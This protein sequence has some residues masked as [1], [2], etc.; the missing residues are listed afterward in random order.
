MRL[1]LAI[2]N[3][4]GIGDFAIGCRGSETAGGHEGGDDDVEEAHLSWYVGDF[5]CSCQMYC[6]L[7]TEVWAWPMEVRD[8]LEPGGYS[9]SA[10]P[11]L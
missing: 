4:V 5:F 2:S 8:V 9:Q 1:G 7:K 11:F 6:G 3:S 10:V